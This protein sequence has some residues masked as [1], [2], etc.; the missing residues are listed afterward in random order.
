MPYSVEDDLC[1]QRGLQFTF[2]YLLPRVAA[3]AKITYGDIADKLRADLS[4][5][6]AV[7]P[8]HV[9]YVVGTLMEQIH[10]AESTAPLINVLVVNQKT[11]EPGSGA[12]GFLR[13]RFGTIKGRRKLIAKAAGEVY[14][15]AGWARIYRKLFKTEPPAVSGSPVAGRNRP[16]GSPA[17][18][19]GAR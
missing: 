17:R 18:S 10:D 8:T 19:A 2:G 5:D 16:P 12:N 14:A 9:G 6:G 4:I 1:S 7:F 13:N 11:G 15:Y 3:N